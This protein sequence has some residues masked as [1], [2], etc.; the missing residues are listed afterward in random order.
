VLTVGASDD[1]ET[2]L[3]DL[4]AEHAPTDALERD[5]VGGRSR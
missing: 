1:F 2:R 5:L 3:K 4:I